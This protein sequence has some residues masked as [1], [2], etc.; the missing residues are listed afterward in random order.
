MDLVLRPLCQ[1]LEDFQSGV[2]ISSNIMDTVA[3]AHAFLLYWNLLW[4]D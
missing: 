2:I 3:Y 1:T 4:G